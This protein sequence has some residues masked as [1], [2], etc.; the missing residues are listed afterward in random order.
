MQFVLKDS[1]ESNVTSALDY[2]VGTRWVPQR[3][4]FARLLFSTSALQGTHST[5]LG[6]EG[7][8]RLFCASAQPLSADLR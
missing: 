4:S 3:Y 1:P 5:E 8:H 6:R 7:A 2:S